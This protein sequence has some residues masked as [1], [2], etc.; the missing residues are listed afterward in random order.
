M[1][2]P[3]THASKGKKASPHQSHN[4]RRDTPV[5]SALFTITLLVF[6]GWLGFA[7]SIKPNELLVDVIVTAIL[8]LFA[9]SL[10]R[11]ERQALHFEVHDLFQCWRVPWY[12]LTGCWEITTLLARDLLMGKRT[13]SFYR[14]CGFKIRKHDPVLR[15]RSILAVTY[16]TMAPNFIVI[17]IDSN[18]R[19]MLFHQI[20]RSSIPRMS[21]S[22][23]AEL[24]SHS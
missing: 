23:G 7:A 19:Q 11:S 12:V 3:R 5:S 17:G 8:T 1:T 4:R 10:L 6:A 22:L 15:A 2:D 14:A 20:E 16:T 9:F 18:Q 21:R 24:E 13:R